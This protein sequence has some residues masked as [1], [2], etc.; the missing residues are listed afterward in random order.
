MQMGVYKN[1]CLELFG[2]IP[3][4]YVYHF[5]FL[6]EQQSALKGKFLD[7]IDQEL[8][9]VLND[10]SLCR[11]T[12]NWKP[13]PS[14]LCYWCPFHGHSPNADP[15]FVGMCQYFSLWTPENK[16]FK[17]HRQYYENIND[18]KRFEW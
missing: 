15:E 14:P 4:E 17:T 8:V 3:V 7:K 11:R 6:D 16:T 13:Q 9:D 5:V 2:K 18:V 1:A 12:D 10:Y